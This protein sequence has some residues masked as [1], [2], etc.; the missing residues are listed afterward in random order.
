MVYKSLYFELRSYLL[1]KQPVATADITKSVKDFFRDRFSSSHEVRCSNSKSSEYLTDVLVTNFNP[2][3]IVQPH[4]LEIVP[5][6]IE[7]FMAVES[8]IGGP[9]ASSAYGVM[10]N[11][12]EDYLKLLV[13]RCQFRVMVFTSLPYSNEDNHVYKRVEVLRSLY[14]RATD[15][16]SGLLLVHLSGSQPNSSQVQALV[17]ADSIRGFEISTDGLSFHEI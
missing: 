17:N 2:V 14:Q 12:V 13:I 4:T 7:V 3:K 11:V 6:T 1:S 10:K 15:V 9:G 16:N 8:E 5:T